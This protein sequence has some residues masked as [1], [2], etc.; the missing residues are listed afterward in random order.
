MEHICW[1]TTCDARNYG[2]SWV[3]LWPLNHILLGP[4]SLT[5]SKNPVD[6]LNFCPGR[7]END[8]IGQKDICGRQLFFIFKKGNL[9][10]VVALCNVSWSCISLIWYWSSCS[11]ITFLGGLNNFQANQALA[12][13]DVGDH[14]GWSY[15]SDGSQVNWPQTSPCL[16][17]MRT[18][19]HKGV[20][21]LLGTRRIYLKQPQLGNIK[22]RS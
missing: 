5:I 15:F 1:L 12:M 18:A 22:T 8:K 6:W 9:R 20:N 19:V 11:Q 2:P 14:G 4:L 17:S 21:M 10:R 3:L 16:K 7:L 13:T